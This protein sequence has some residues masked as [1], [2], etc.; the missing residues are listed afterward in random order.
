[1]VK[2][3]ANQTERLARMEAKTEANLQEIKEEIKIDSKEIKASKEEMKEKMKTKMDA[4][5]ETTKQGNNTR[6][7]GLA[8]RNLDRPRRDGGLSRKYGRKFRGN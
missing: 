6:H 2:I 7:E 5:Q 4:I 8:K 3:K 1:L